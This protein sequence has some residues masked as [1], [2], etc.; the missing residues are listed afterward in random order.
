MAEAELPDLGPEVCWG[1]IPESGKG[2]TPQF[3]I[4]F[5]KVISIS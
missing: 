5:C 4:G 2:E 1:T 3:Q